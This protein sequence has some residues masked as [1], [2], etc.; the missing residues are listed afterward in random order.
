LRLSSLRFPQKGN[1]MKKA[2]AAAFFV[3]L[4]CTSFAVRADDAEQATLAAQQILTLIANDRLYALWDTRVSKFFKDRVGKDVFLANLSQGRVS[5]GGARLSSHLVDI[6]YAN[7]EPE[8]GYKGDIYT[9][10][11][12]SKYP[13]G[14]FYE[15]VVLIKEPDG[16]FRL[17]GISAAPAPRD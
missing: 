2:I 5:V 4:L 1:E 17:S 12:L 10:R 7:Q 13:G 8:S 14:N 11:F 9:C 6:T 3:W 15:S 16:Q